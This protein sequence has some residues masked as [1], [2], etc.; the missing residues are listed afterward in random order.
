MPD[1][2]NQQSMTEEAETVREM[3]TFCATAR[4]FFP[5]EAMVQMCAIAKFLGDPTT[6]A[7]KK[8]LLEMVLR[9]R[10]GLQRP[11]TSEQFM[12]DLERSERIGS[13]AQI[14]V[15]QPRRTH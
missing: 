9:R 5:D 10:I 6:F 1:N 8:R 11:Y 13:P 12:I 7:A 14:I 3:A 4:R 2:N 15:F